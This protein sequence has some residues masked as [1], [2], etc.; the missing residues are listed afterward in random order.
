MLQF[1]TIGSEMTLPPQEVSQAAVWMQEARHRAANLQHL[2]ANVDYMLDRGHINPEDRPRM[3]RRAAALLQSYEALKESGG[4]PSPCSAELGTIACGLVEM[5]GHTIGSVVLVLDLQPIELTGDRRRALLLATSELVINALRHAFAGRRF[6]II[7]I[8]L[9]CGQAQ[10]EATLRVADDGVG[11]DRIGC[12]SGLGCRI[13]RGLAEVLNG[14]VAWER[15][16][17]LGGT[18]AVLTF[19]LAG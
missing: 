3:V 6:G 19:R 18:E 2:V 13:I 8:G 11:P 4:E 5:F 16:S 9:G 1:G 15:S 7:Q 14:H 10:E 17:L 12:G